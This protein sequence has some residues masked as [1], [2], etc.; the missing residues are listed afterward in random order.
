MAI[1]EGGKIQHV[2]CRNGMKMNPDWTTSPLEATCNEH[3]EWELN[4]DVN[5]SC[6][7]G[8][9]NMLPSYK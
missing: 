3:L 8:T 2:T 4:P 9:M 5:Y 7:P 6:V 1:S